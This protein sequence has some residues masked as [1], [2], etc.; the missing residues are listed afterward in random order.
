MGHLRYK[1]ALLLATILLLAYPPPLLSQTPADALDCSTEQLYPLGVYVFCSL[2]S[3]SI[4]FTCLFG[5]GRNAFTRWTN[6]PQCYKIRKGALW[7]LNCQMRCKPLPRCCDSTAVADVTLAMNWTNAGPLFMFTRILGLKC[8]GNGACW[9]DG[10]YPQCDASGMS[11]NNFVPTM[12]CSW[13]LGN[14][15]RVRC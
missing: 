15:K 13:R 11:T 2:P 10:G 3:P 9:W 5:G 7:C 4:R 14:F 6:N 1:P 8:P 12:P